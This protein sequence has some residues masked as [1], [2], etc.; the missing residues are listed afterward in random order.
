ME[1][2]RLPE[3]PCA[4]E[5]YLHLQ[6]TCDS[7]AREIAEV[8]ALTVNIPVLDEAYQPTDGILWARGYT[9]QKK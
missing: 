7:I 3:H 5:E 2:T 8:E 6:E 4:R 1:Q 9:W